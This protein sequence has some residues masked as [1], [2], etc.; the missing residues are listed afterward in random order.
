MVDTRF[1]WARIDT[2]EP[3]GSV[4]SSLERRNL[5]SSV[6]SFSFSAEAVRIFIFVYFVIVYAPHSA[7]GTHINRKKTDK[8][9]QLEC[10]KANSKPRI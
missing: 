5:R 3:H 6:S 7:L 4:Y 10:K 8:R 2:N 9:Q 1:Y